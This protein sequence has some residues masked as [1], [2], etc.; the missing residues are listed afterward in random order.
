VAAPD[1]PDEPRRPS[2]AELE[3]LLRRAVRGSDV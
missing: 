3:D 1:L 2:P